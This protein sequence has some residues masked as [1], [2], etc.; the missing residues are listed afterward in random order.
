LKRTRFIWVL[1]LILLCLQAKPSIGQWLNEKRVVIRDLEYYMATDK[2]EYAQGEVVGMLYK[3][4]NL[5]SDSVTFTFGSTQIYDFYVVDSSEEEI[6]RWSWDEFFS[7]M[8]LEL[9]L[10]PGDSTL[11]S[12]EW[13][14]NNPAGDTVL[15]GECRV[16]GTYVYIS[17]PLYPVSVRIVVNPSSVGERGASTLPSRFSIDQNYPNPFNPITEIQYALPRDCWVRLEVYNILGQKVAKLIDERQEAGYKAVRWDAMAVASGIYIYRIQ[18]GDF[19]Q[20]R[21]MILLK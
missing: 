21:R 10:G 13:D 6:W 20:T 1:S 8:V 19:A 11:A 3:I 9:P 15:P 14:M 4:T 16:T 7:P 5:G 2:A 17:P 12:C 18:A